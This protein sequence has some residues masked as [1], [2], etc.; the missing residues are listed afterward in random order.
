M[1]DAVIV[2]KLILVGTQVFSRLSLTV[3]FLLI[4]TMPNTQTAHLEVLKV[5]TQATT[6]SVVISSIESYKDFLQLRQM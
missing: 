4:S 3:L 1:T 5:F 2:I 6:F